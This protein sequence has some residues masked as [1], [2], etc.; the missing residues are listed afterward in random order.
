MINKPKLITFIIA[1]IL[2][3]INIYVYGINDNWSGILYIFL[4][5]VVLILVGLYDIGK[6]ESQ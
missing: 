5:Y 6:D 2:L 1:T 4:M 3:C